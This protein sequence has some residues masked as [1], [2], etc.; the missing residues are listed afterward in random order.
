MKLIKENLIGINEFLGPQYTNHTMKQLYEREM[1]MKK[2]SNIIA[3]HGIKSCHGNIVPDDS[4][5]CGE[6]LSSVL[7]SYG[8]ND[9]AVSF[10]NKA[11]DSSNYSKSDI[12][13]IFAKYATKKRS[14]LAYLDISGNNISLKSN[15]SI[16]NL[17]SIVNHPS[18]LFVNISNN[19]L[20]ALLHTASFNEYQMR[21]IIWIDQYSLDEPFL[22]E[23]VRGW[24][25]RYYEI[26][27]RLRIGPCEVMKNCSDY[28][29]RKFIRNNK[30]I[31]GPPKI[32]NKSSY[33]NVKS[34]YICGPPKKSY[35]N[36]KSN[37]ICGPPYENV[38]SNYICCESDTNSSED[39]CNDYSS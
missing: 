17:K 28:Y 10:A 22:E 34:N 35:E 25:R 32:C 12:M 3:R 24:H 16:D 15:G 8:S 13:R 1:H 4:N 31:C 37:Y 20:D 6:T 18:I 9:I 27:N 19:N 38:K 5:R 29:G 11:I 14:K 23:D 21:K 36:V 30:D 2:F 26:I 39:D 33:E 7:S